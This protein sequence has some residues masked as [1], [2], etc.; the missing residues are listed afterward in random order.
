MRCV[1]GGRPAA[2]Y[3]SGSTGTA[4]ATAAGGL[5]ACGLLAAAPSAAEQ[6][7]SEDPWT[8]PG[9]YVGVGT[10]SL[11]VN[12]VGEGGP[13]VVFESGLGGTSL[14]WRQVQSAVARFARSCTYDRAGYGWSE[15]G[16]LPRHAGQLSS[17]LATLLVYASL[18]PPYVLVAH[19]FGGF[20]VRLYANRNP[21]KVAALVLVDTT[22]EQQFKRYETG[23]P[24]VPRG[25]AFI[26]ANHWA[27]PD[28]LPDGIKTLAQRLALRPRAVRAL[29]AELADMRR[30][31][32]QVQ[33]RS[34]LPAVPIRV[35]ARG[36]RITD[37]N[38]TAGASER[39]W[40]EAQRDLAT[41]LPGA[42]LHLARDS[43][44][45]VH[46]DAPEFV[47]EVIRNVVV[48]AGSAQR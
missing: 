47:V 37:G 6:A 12:C 26:I 10:H 42:S 4:K 38:A 28:G 21:E 25:R 34:Q 32:V 20:P 3:D 33:Q 7:L 24:F 23:K 46:L 48:E 16:P 29:Y 30:S 40:R 11:H 1:S 5:L 43:G 44:H 45:H 18:P 39:R 17:E 27:V 9:M 36:S 2:S 8:P 13:T 41:R 19:S 15:S 14:E 35:V 22:H 31:A